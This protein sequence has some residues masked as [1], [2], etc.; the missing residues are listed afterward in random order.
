MI[1]TI[2]NDFTG[3]LP[4]AFYDSGS[5]KILTTLHN[6]KI[7]KNKNLHKDGTL[8]SEIEYDVNSNISKITAYQNENIVYELYKENN[9]TIEKVNLQN[10]LLECKLIDGKLT[11]IAKFS[12]LLNCLKQNNNNHNI[13]NLPNNIYELIYNILTNNIISDN[14]DNNYIICNYKKKY[15]KWKI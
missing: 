6:G 3:E 9:K 12:K 11:G 15:F 4:S 5:I 10:P 8:L 2:S 7:A 1:N 14:N 13:L